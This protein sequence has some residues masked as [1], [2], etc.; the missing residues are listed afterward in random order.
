MTARGDFT[1]QDDSEEA[2]DEERQRLV[3]ILAQVGLRPDDEGALVQ[4]RK[5]EEWHLWPENLAVWEFWRALQTQWMRGGMDGRATGLNH[6]SVWAGIDGL[7]M[8]GRRWVFEVIT[9]ME[10]AT[11][12]EWHEQAKQ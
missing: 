6:A 7:R 8:R 11:L 12:E 10:Q 5:T 9:Q 2:I 1:D 4:R 3:R